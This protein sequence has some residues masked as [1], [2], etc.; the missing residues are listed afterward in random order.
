MFDKL[1]PAWSC[2]VEKYTVPF[3]N[4]IYCIR[5]HLFL[6]TL[7]K[8]RVRVTDIQIHR[9]THTNTQLITVCL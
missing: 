5:Q 2:D 1:Q 7:E 9:H 4:A 8:Y 6:A 3:Y